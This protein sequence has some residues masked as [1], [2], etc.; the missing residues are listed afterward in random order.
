MWLASALQPLLI[1]YKIRN[2]MYLFIE[3]IKYTPHVPNF[4]ACLIFYGQIDQ[5]LTK[6]CIYIVGSKNIIKFILLESICILL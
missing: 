6:L 5:I 4:S 1:L 2:D 3:I